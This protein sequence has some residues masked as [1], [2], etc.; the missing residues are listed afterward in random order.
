MPVTR[1][2][3]QNKFIAKLHEDSVIATSQE[4]NGGD[5]VALLP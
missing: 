4:D 5:R 2:R 3:K 1:Y